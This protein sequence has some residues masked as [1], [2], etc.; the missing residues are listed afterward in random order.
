M[1]PSSA[2][3]RIYILQPLDLVNLLANPDLLSQKVPLESHKDVTCEEL[4]SG[5]FGNDFTKLMQNSLRGECSY[6]P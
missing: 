1:P 4:R 6:S 2:G 5:K 3:T